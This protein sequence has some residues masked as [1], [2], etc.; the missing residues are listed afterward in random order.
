MI[1]YNLTGETIDWRLIKNQK[2]YSAFRSIKQ[3]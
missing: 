3:F 1:G 2:E